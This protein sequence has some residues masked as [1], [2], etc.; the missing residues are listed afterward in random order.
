MVKKGKNKHRIDYI[1]C[2]VDDKLLQ[3]SNKRTSSEL[4]LVDVWSIKI[5]PHDS[6]KVLG[7]IRDMSNDDPHPLQHVKRLQKLE[8]GLLTVILCSVDLASR[9]E[10]VSLLGEKGLGIETIEVR[11]VPAHCP[12]TKD[13]ALE[14]GKLYWPLVWKGNPNDQI[15]N[16]MVFNFDHIRS[17]LQLIC[18]NSSKC[19]EQLPISTVIVDPLTN[20][21]IASSN[22]ERH[23]HPLDHSVMRC[24]QLVS[25]YEQQRRESIDDPSDHH[26][27]CN[28]YHVYT[29]HEPCTMCAMALIHSR[30]ARLFYLKQSPKTGALD[31]ES[32][33]GYTIHDH[34]L[35]N[36]KFEV[37]KWIG[38]EYQ[39]AD[40][41]ENVNA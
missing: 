29:T 16:E 9:E 22:D 24:I 7:L 28:N 30:I 21:V 11:Q 18:T 12:P 27:L 33:P 40:L 4:S 3:I 25:E 15:L 38:D 35:L 36:S 10:V 8:D 31:P 32:G 39:V 6:P 19:C 17:D 1:H 5:Q 14:W 2:T 41:D 34:K 13:M 26:Y 37:F 20:A 23:R